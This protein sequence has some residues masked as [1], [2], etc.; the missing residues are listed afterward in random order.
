MADDRG[1][2]RWVGRMAD[3]RE[4]YRRSTKAAE[5]DKRKKRIPTKCF[6]CHPK[7]NMMT[8]IASERHENGLPSDVQ[9]RL[10]HLSLSDSR[11][12]H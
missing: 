11:P 3:D 6:A 2:Y 8:S 9:Y 10:R 1:T 12:S 4:T 5:L 7:I